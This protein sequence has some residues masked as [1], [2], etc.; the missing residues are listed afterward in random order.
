MLLISWNVS[1][2]SRCKHI[3]GNGAI[4]KLLHKR[5][6]TWLRQGGSEQSVSCLVF[7][8][9]WRH[10][11]EQCMSTWLCIHT[12]LCHGTTRLIVEQQPCACLEDGGRSSMYAVHGHLARL[13]QRCVRDCALRRRV[14]DAQCGENGHIAGRRYTAIPLF[15]NAAFGLHPLGGK[16]TP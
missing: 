15:S 13:V 7:A 12:W 4:S 14:T 16:E 10:C 5:G 1:M 6:H 3:E 9:T 2:W 8:V 11:P